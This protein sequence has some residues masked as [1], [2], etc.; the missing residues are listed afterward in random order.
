MSSTVDNSGLRGNILML[1]TL[2]ITLVLP[3][4]LILLSYMEIISGTG[5]YIAATAVI[6]STIYVVGGAFW[7]FSQDAKDGKNLA[8]G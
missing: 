4:A 5:S 7:M 8:D 1:G 2:V 6:L 3:L